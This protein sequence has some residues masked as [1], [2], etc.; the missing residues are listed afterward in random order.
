[1]S[2]CGGDVSVA[3]LMSM[4]SG[5]L[6]A[7]AVYQQHLPLP[8]PL[9]SEARHEHPLHCEDLGGAG[10]EREQEEGGRSREGAGAAGGGGRG[11]WRKG[12]GVGRGGG[13]R[14]AMAGW[15]K[16]GGYRG[17]RMYECIVYEC[18]VYEC[19]VYECIVWVYR[20]LCT[21]TRWFSMVY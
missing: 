13:R 6:I 10:A 20:V 19:I 17:S 12:E 15:R 2:H 8:T 18:I 9:L 11:G 14:G 4:L 21:C 16:V 5:L 3:I 7:L 1:V